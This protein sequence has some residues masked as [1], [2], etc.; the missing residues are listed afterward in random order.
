MKTF[1]FKRL[2]LLAILIGGVLI[3]SGCSPCEEGGNQQLSAAW[4]AMQ[5]PVVEG[6]EICACSKYASC[7]DYI[8]I[9]HKTANA[10]ELVDEYSEKL[11]S[12]GWKVEPLGTSRMTLWATKDNSEVEL[13]FKEC[14]KHITKPGTWSSCIDIGVTKKK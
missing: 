13:F 9:A 7:D 10:L 11:K 14:N 8:S 2:S 6:G 4:T 5:F 1:K 12:N 3:L